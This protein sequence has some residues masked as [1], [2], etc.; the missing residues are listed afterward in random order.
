MLK[1][2]GKSALN[3]KPLSAANTNTYSTFTYTPLKKS[4]PEHSLNTTLNPH[5][6]ACMCAFS[7]LIKPPV[8]LTSSHPQHSS[9]YV[10]ALNSQM[11][12]S[13][14]PESEIVPGKGKNLI[15]DQ[16]FNCEMLCEVQRWGEIETVGN[17][18]I[19]TV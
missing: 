18:F 7:P 12:R 19:K 14:E 6:P 3:A 11:C 1:P 15:R 9:S 8:M 17:V 16:H 4:K 2:A 13:A 5:P 10:F